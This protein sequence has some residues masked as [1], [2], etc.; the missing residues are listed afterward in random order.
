MAGAA[1]AAAANPWGQVVE[2]F[3]TGA[4]NA[5]KGATMLLRFGAAGGLGAA[6]WG[7]PLAQPTGEGED[8]LVQQGKEQARQ[9]ALQS[10]HDHGGGKN[11][12]HGKA[13]S[14]PS[15]EKQLE[16]LQAQYDE[17]VRTQGSRKEKKNI[18]SRID[19]IKENMARQ[20]KGE[21]HHHRDQ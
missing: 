16:D 10:T 6:I 5:A 8:K 12:Q 17:L 7:G 9:R 1:G 21:S 2:T 15:Q 20:K 4:S 11:A 14:K 18:K 3:A 19:N 13:E